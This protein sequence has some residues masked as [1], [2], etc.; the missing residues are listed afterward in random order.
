MRSRIWIVGG[1]RAGRAK[2]NEFLRALLR[3]EHDGVSMD[4][5]FETPLPDEGSVYDFLFECKGKGA[6]L[7]YGRAPALAS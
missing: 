5:K 6:P 7:G 1:G 3:D 2:F 4:V